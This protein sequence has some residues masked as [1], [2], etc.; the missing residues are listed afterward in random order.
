LREQTEE[1]RIGK[2]EE[3]LIATLWQD[4]NPDA[5]VYEPGARLWCAH[6][7]YEF[8]SA[9]PDYL[10][11]WDDDPSNVEPLEC[12]SD[13]GGHGWGSED[14]GDI[15]YH[16]RL[17]V[18]QQCFVFGAE[19]GH[20]MLKKGKRT[21]AYVVPFGQEE[22]AEYMRLITVYLRPFMAM[23]ATGVSPDIDGHEAT[24][25][26]LIDLN[27]VEDGEVPIPNELAEAFVRSG[28]LLDQVKEEYRS[29]QNEVRASMGRAKY[30]LDGSGRRVAERRVYKVPDTVH[31]AHTVDQLRK[32]R[33]L[34]VKEKQEADVSEDGPS[35]QEGQTDG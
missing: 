33:S 17:Q 12:K 11:I 6:P 24:T 16:Y 4:R 23:M 35:I 15:P 2:L 30:A 8:I 31:K 26:I 20:V 21:R 10:V 3:P 32:V 29:L 25:E 14:S 13:D 7:P 5:V 9:T 19:R 27:P 28:L 22:R 18:W 34:F 1:M